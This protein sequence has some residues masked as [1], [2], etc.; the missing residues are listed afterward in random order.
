MIAWNKINNS[1]FAS[2]Y[3]AEI[4]VKTIDVAISICINVDFYAL[5]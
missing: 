5:R 3:R 1:I 4:F 2:F